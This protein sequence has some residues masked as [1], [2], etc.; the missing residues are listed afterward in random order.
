[1][2]KLSALACRALL[3]TMPGLALAD[4]SIPSQGKKP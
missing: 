3:F 4:A 1:M 2:R